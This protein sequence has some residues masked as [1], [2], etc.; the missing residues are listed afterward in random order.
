MGEE[1]KKR[2]KRGKEKKKKK[3]KKKKKIKKKKKREKKRERIELVMA[4]M[5]VWRIGRKR[6]E[7]G[8]KRGREEEKNRWRGRGRYKEGKIIGL[9]MRYGIYERGVRVLQVYVINM[10]YINYNK[11]LKF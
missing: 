10:L 2:K 6:R 4:R 7:G 3:K 8:K 9:M 5:I 11:R 1:K